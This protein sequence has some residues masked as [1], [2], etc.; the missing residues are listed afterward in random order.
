MLKKT[1][2]NC[3]QDFWV[4]SVKDYLYKQNYKDKETGKHMMRYY[5]CRSCMK[6]DM[7]VRKTQRTMK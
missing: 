1:C 7:E 5:C 3:G 4:E 6:I 2:T